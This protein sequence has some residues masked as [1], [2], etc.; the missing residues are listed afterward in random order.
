MVERVLE[1]LWQVLAQVV[2]RRALAG[3]IAVGPSFVL[4]DFAGE[5]LSN[6]RDYRDVTYIAPDADVSDV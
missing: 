1:S 6:I 2:D 5:Q 3:R 4:V